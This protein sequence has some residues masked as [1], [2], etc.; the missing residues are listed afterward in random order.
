MY[1]ITK[2]FDLHAMA[3]QV[4]DCLGHGKHKKA[5]NL[6]METAGQETL[7]G[8]LDDLSEFAGMG[9]TQFDKIPFYDVKDRCR[10]SDKQKVLDCFGIDINIV[11]WTDL[12][13]NPLLCFI[14][15][16]LKY[17]KIEEPIP[18]TLE[19]R[20]KYWKKYYN[21]ELGKGTAKEYVYNNIK[22]I[23]EYQAWLRL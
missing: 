12:R 15:T 5:V 8:K 17:K 21:S 18:L 19:E 6:L 14:F 20:G 13:Y 11:E 16:R 1:G 4:C 10:E 9:L 7:L 2:G 3:K 22:L 23:K